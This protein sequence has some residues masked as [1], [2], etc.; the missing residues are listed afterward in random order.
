MKLWKILVVVALLAVGFFVFRA[1]RKTTYTNFPPRAT[2]DW[3][4][5]G[6]SLTSGFG[7]SGGNDYPTLLSAR[8][9]RKILNKGV[10]GETTENALNRVEEI[11]RLKPRV[12][13]LCFGG[14]DGL[15]QLPMDKTFANLSTI[16]DRLQA[17]GSFVVLIGVRSA[18][19][20]D[21]YASHFKKLAKEKHVL[22]V[23]NILKGVL[24]SPKLMSDYI[25]PN[26]EGYEAI[27]ERLEKILEPF[28][29]KL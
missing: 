22:Y 18:S 17:N 5:F 16:I 7:A 8:I 6:D 12:V 15:Q 21:R 29:S 2:E 28:L 23:P 20:S 19:I 1:C 27:A 25:H 13:L 9:G 11:V 26:D 14:N 4:A 10:P 3:V 24:G